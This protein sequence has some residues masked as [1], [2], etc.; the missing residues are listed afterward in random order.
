METERNRKSA[1]PLSR[2]HVAHSVGLQSRRKVPAVLYSTSF[3]FFWYL[4]DKREGR[5]VMVKNTK[6]KKKDNDLKPYSE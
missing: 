6:L 5:G 1:Q 2:F 4:W 3:F